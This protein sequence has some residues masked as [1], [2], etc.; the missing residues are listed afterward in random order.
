MVGSVWIP[1][2]W[3]IWKW[4]LT[5]FLST[6]MFAWESAHKIWPC[7]TFHAGKEVDKLFLLESIQTL[8]GS[9]FFPSLS[10]IQTFFILFL[11]LQ[12]LYF[13]ILLSFPS[14]SK[15]YASAD[16]SLPSFLFVTSPTERWSPAMYY[17]QCYTR[18]RKWVWQAKVTLFSPTKIPPFHPRLN[19]TS[20]LNKMNFSDPFLFWKIETF[21]ACSKMGK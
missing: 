21:S 12:I 8:Y 14:L 5:I 1:H 10:S 3:G 11:I 16:E 20:T 6:Q 19:L 13:T 18:D 4:N 9:I 15:P 2:A 7:V 17:I